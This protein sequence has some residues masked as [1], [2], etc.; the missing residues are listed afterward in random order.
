MSQGCVVRRSG[1]GG[2]ALGWRVSEWV[3]AEGIKARARAENVS[4][5]RAGR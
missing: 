2:W 4:C 5:R 1:E 3:A